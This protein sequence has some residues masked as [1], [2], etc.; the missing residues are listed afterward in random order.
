MSKWP[1]LQQVSIP[2]YLKFA[3]QGSAADVK[4]DGAVMITASHLPFNRNGFKFFDAKAG[5][6][7]KEISDLLRRAA[8][9]A[10]AG[11]LDES[12]SFPRDSRQAEPEAIA[13]LEQ[14]LNVET[15][16]VHKVSTASRSNCL[17]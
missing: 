13:E 10:G 16:L 15:S 12:P 5:F 17:C 14:S 7:K 3:K 2:P 1:A 11:N 9:D 4:A 8:E 6:E